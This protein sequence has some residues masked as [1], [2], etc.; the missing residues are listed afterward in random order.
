MLY[1]PI[2]FPFVYMTLLRFISQVFTIKIRGA[3][4]LE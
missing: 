4:Q 1:V 3:I 2:T